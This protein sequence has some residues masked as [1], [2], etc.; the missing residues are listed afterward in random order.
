[1]FLFYRITN[2]KKLQKP[3]KYSLEK[4]TSYA[5]K[6]QFSKIETY[7]NAYHIIRKYMRGRNKN[8]YSNF[9]YHLF[10]S[11]ASLLVQYFQLSSNIQNTT[12]RRVLLGKLFQRRCEYS[13]YNGS[14]EQYFDISLNIQNILDIFYVRRGSTTKN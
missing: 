2:G 5:M 3:G 6:K 7:L 9:E 13:K 10:S 8:Q 1:M 14:M 4:W 12:P 11:V